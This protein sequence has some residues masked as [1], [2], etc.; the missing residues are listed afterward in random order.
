MLAFRENY[1]VPIIHMLDRFITF[2]KQLDLLVSCLGRVIKRTVTSAAFVSWATY[3]IASRSNGQRSMLA[4]RRV[5]IRRLLIFL[6]WNFTS[7]IFLWKTLTQLMIRSNNSG[8]RRYADYSSNILHAITE[9]AGERKQW[10]EY[11][12]V[13][14]K[15]DLLVTETRFGFY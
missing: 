8:S 11:L 14:C 7:E 12:F 3:S 9:T 4:D 2:L 15:G 6:G 1:V 5:H 13:G 10:G